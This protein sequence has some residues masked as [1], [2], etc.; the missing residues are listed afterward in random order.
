MTSAPIVGPSIAGYNADGLKSFLIFA[1]DNGVLPDILSWHTFFGTHETVQY[2]SQVQEMQQFM[3]AHGIHITRFSINESAQFTSPGPAIWRMANLER[4]GVESSIGSCWSNDQCYGSE[5]GWLNGIIAGGG[6]GDS[7]PAFKGYADLSG[8]VVDVA[9]AHNFEAVASHDPGRGEARIIV[10]ADGSGTRSVN[11][12]ITN[13]NSIGHVIN[14]GQVRVSTYLLDFDHVNGEM[15]SSSIQTV[16]NGQITVP[17]T[18]GHNEG[19]YQIVLSNPT[20][21]PGPAPSPS[22]SPSRP[23]APA[24]VPVRTPQPARAGT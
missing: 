7:W 23:P 19:G 11:V 15:E 24:P 14:N 22:P 3:A 5:G 13:L 6:K 2:I 1:R 21:T 9:P 4:A 12:R 20:G 18:V 16:S 10:G 8:R 17:I